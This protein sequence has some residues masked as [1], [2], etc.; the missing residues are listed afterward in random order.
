MA[1]A[2]Q[3]GAEVI[4]DSA[5]LKG[6]YQLSRTAS[7]KPPAATG[8]DVDGNTIMI[9][10]LNWHLPKCSLFLWEK[11]EALRPLL[12]IQLDKTTTA[13]ILCDAR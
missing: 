7:A 6:P 11:G 9:I 4:Y 1:S 8:T 5:F 10:V 12:L 13:S 2:A 3:E